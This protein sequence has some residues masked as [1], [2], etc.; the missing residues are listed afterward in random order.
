MNDSDQIIN[1]FPEE[2]KKPE[3]IEGQTRP[4]VEINYFSLGSPCEVPQAKDA[5]SPKA[6]ELSEESD[7]PSSISNEPVEGHANSAKQSLGSNRSPG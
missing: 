5:E 6:S 3:L 7:V 4:K 2:Q 1:P